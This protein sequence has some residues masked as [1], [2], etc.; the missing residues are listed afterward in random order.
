MWWIGNLAL[1][2]IVIPVVGQLLLGVRDAALT[3][4]AAVDDVA[5][6]GAGIL[7]GLEP[8]PE[9]VT[10]QGFVAETA[11]GLARYGGALDKVL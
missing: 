4:R 10:T 1:A 2:V 3:I 7:R 9:L 6:V 5:E 8:V 11:A